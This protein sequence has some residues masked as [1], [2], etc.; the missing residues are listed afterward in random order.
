MK[1]T[2][3]RWLTGVIIALFASLINPS[4]AQEPLR[5]FLRADCKATFITSD[6]LGNIYTLEGSTLTCL[7]SSLKIQYTYSNLNSGLFT[8]VDA[9]DPLKLMLFSR[10]F[11]TLYFLDQKLTVQGSEI[12]LQATVP[13]GNIT[14]ACTSY[15]SGFWVFDASGVQLLRFGSNAELQQ[16]SGNINMM[17]GEELHPQFLM[18]HSNMVYLCDTARGIFIFDRYGAYL[19]H[20]PFFRVMSIQA[21]G[22]ILFLFSP[23]KIIAYNIIDHTLSEIN[24]P[25]PF[26]SGC[27]RNGKLYLLTGREMII[28]K[29]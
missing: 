26:I 20:L 21:R 23:A 19:K 13:A 24:A 2:F 5:E 1:T 29:M 4:S 3:K 16:S 10:E 8:F 9:A 14:L 7:D 11:S 12:D 27:I 17:A 6:H 25:E 28:L 22:D 15:E 18:E